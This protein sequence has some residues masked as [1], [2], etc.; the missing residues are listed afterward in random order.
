MLHHHT[1]VPEPHADVVMGLLQLVVSHMAWAQA[2]DVSL[3]KPSHPGLK[4]Y[5]FHSL[6][7]FS[8]SLRAGTGLC[9]AKGSGQWLAAATRSTGAREPLEAVFSSRWGR[10]KGAQVDTSFRDGAHIFLDMLY[11]HQ[12]R[13]QDHYSELLRP[14]L[15]LRQVGEV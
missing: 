6:L 12:E 5:P 11:E 9:Y 10:G 1:Q 3:G 7:I 2:T 13:G 4:P 8:C 14:W 15:T